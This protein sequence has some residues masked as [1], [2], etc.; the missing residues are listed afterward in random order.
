MKRVLLG[1]S[2]L[3]IAACAQQPPPPPVAASPPP[4]APAPP[5]PPTT[6]T[7]YFD[8]N[9]SRLDPGAREVIR[10][11]ANSALSVSLTTVQVTGYADPAGSAGYNQRLSLR[12]AKVVAGQLLREGVPRGALVV[13][14]QG[15]TSDAPTPG[16]DR[17]VE[18]IVGGPPPERSPPRSA[19]PPAS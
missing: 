15:E 18:V 4:P 17:R 1:C 12:R 19:P 6:F 16:Q 11:A 2:L 9:S 14:G 13:S 5:P 8:D 10:F 3:A 7:V